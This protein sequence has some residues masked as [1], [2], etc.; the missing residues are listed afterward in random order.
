MVFDVA[1]G[2]GPGTLR[3]AREAG[4]LAVGVDRDHSALGPFVLTSVLKRY[5]NG[6]AY[7]LRQVRTGRI[8]ASGLRVMGLRRGGAGLGRLSPRVP[9][10]LRAE[11]A[12]LRTRII[13][14]GL[15][16]AD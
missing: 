15:P 5:D 2:C 1:G 11:L 4:V 3:A 9:D 8:R 6:F 14:R 12:R 7:L 13:A 16:P 10:D